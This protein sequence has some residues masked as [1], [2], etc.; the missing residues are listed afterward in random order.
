MN[1][2]YEE[3]GYEQGWIAGAGS[4]GQ[5]VVLRRW[6]DGLRCIAKECKMGSLSPTEKASIRKE[7][8]L[9]SSFDHPNIV[10]FFDSFEVNDTLYI[11]MEF[12]DGGD[13]QQQI[14]LQQD[15]RAAGQEEPWPEMHIMAWFLQLCLALKYLHDRKVLHRDLKSGNVFLT[16]GGIVKLGDFGL[17]TTLANTVANAQTV[18]G[19]P[20][21]FSPELCLNEAYNNKSDIWALGCILYEMCTL[22]HPFEAKNMKL[23]VKEILNGACNPL[24]PTYS[25][26]MQDLL[27]CMLERDAHQRLS[28]DGVLSTQF[29]QEWLVAIYGAITSDTESEAEAEL[30]AEY[31]DWE[32]SD[33]A[34]SQHI[35]KK[36]DV[37]PEV[38]KQKVA[39]RFADKQDPTSVDDGPKTITNISNLRSVLKGPPLKSV[40]VVR[41]QDP[42]DSMPNLELESAAECY[43]GLPEERWAHE[44][45]R[46]HRGMAQVIASIVMDGAQ[47]GCDGNF[48][49][50]ETADFA[51]TLMSHMG[52]TNLWDASLEVGRD[53][54]SIRSQPSVITSEQKAALRMFVEDDGISQDEEVDEELLQRLE[55]A[56][57]DKEASLSPLLAKLARAVLKTESCAAEGPELFSS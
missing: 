21:Y 23:L 10:R 20:Y 1:P 53:P 34:A 16:R 47:C 29:V 27:A 45:L 11:I 54:G 26:G 52:Q 57:E 17:A 36:P 40:K 24:P 7:A 13:L 4:Y 12:A 35:L 50:E 33:P 19:T 46:A 32:A 42:F 30:M 41:Q 39:E 25:Q 38:L 28:I 48:F 44:R 5:A 51:G 49:S 43:A 15:N 37:E 2:V 31:I 8:Q 14:D 6:K 3:Q 22:E 56:L 18:C 55:A 9:L